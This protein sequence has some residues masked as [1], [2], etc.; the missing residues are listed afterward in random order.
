MPLHP[1]EAC[2][3]DWVKYE[4]QVLLLGMLKC[5][6]F[7]LLAT[8]CWAPHIIESDAAARV[9][10]GLQAWKQDISAWYATGSAAVAMYAGAQANWQA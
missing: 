5:A 4:R 3:R 6:L 10:R 9:Q 7:E 8:V 2:W 1:F